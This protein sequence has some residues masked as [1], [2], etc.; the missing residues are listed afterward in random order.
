MAEVERKWALLV[1]RCSHFWEKRMKF[2]VKK[3]AELQRMDFFF[4]TSLFL[5][6]YFH[7]R[8]G[9]ESS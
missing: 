9:F 3:N 6:V 4:P 1:Y 8:N 7:S 2:N 5:I